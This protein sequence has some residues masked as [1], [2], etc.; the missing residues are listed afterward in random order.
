MLV[1]GSCIAGTVVRFSFDT[2]PI[3]NG[4]FTPATGSIDPE[5]VTCSRD[6]TVSI[7]SNSTADVC[8]AATW[9]FRCVTSEKPRKRAVSVCRPAGTFSRRNRPCESVSVP[10][11]VPSR[12]IWTLD[13][14]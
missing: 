4:D 5:T 6:S 10:T 8:P 3:E 12:K 2:R 14:G 9:M 13:I 1:I 11:F 7:I